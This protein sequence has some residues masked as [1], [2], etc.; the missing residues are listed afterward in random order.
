MLYHHT[1]LVI[2]LLVYASSLPVSSTTALSTPGNV[3]RQ[4][5]PPGSISHVTS[6]SSSV[7]T[8]SVSLVYSSASNLILSSDDVDVKQLKALHTPSSVTLSKPCC[9]G[10]SV[11]TH[12]PIT[13]SCERWIQCKAQVIQLFRDSKQVHHNVS[14]GGCILYCL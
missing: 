3:R 2:Y 8:H 4:I 1:V 7:S 6:P 11:Q 13:N 9:V 12:I 5:F 14:H 10:D